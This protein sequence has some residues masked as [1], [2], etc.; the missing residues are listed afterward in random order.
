MSGTALDGRCVVADGSP[1]ALDATPT[2]D[3]LVL[4]QR[5]A[6]KR[7]GR[8][9]GI[10]VALAAARAAGYAAAVADRG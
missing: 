5:L 10:A 3:E 1:R 4:S 7:V 2:H 8:A 9:Q 6:S